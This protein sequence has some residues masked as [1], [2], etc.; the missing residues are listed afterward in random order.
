MIKYYLLAMLA[1]VL[2][3]VIKYFIVNNLNEDLVII[4]NFFR[5]SYHE[6]YGISFSM[7]SG[8]TIMIL[9]FS[10]LGIYLIWLLLTKHAYHK[11]QLLALALML[12]GAF[13]NLFDRIFRG[14]VV[15]YFQ[16][17]IN[18]RDLAV[19]NVAD[20]FLVVGMAVVII[21]MIL[22]EFNGN[23]NNS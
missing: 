15:D 21:V 4:P 18:G 20:T 6:N 1:F 17:T 8:N 19:F 3:Q 2:D 22:E 9:I 7:L 14:F 12:G 10:L 13:G 5:L 16:F 23:K 11:V